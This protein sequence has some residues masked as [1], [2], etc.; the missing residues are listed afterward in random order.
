MDASPARGSR[1]SAS[2]SLEPACR[3]PAMKVSYLRVFAGGLLAI[4]LVLVL[5]F[6]QLP[7]SPAE[8][9]ARAGGDPGEAAG[10]RGVTVLLWYHP[11]GARRA[12]PDCAALYAI[13]GCIVTAN[14]SAYPRADAVLVPP[15]D[16][17]GNVSRLPQSAR[18]GA[19]K[20]IWMNFESPTHTK[21]LER[22]EGLFNMTMSYKLGSDIFVPYGYLERARAP[23]R[24]VPLPTKR[25]LVAWV[26]SNWNEAHA[27]VV[28]YWN[29]RRYVPIDVYGRA[30]AELVGDSVVRTV[31]AYKFYL[32]WEN[33]QHTD[34]ITEKL[35]H[36]ALQSSAVPV[37]LGPPRSNYE[38]FLPA[39]AFIHV[40]D[41][42]GPAQL[43]AYLRFL[44]RNPRS[45]LR[46]F[47]WKRRYTVHVASFWHEHYCAACAAVRASARHAKVVSDLALWFHA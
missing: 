40:D 25:R 28:F 15:R 31:S 26:V 21:H 16:I 44:A 14:R 41:F 13:P 8:P 24:R 6:R 37:V 5:C 29:L 30:G 20:W 10:A 46:Y 39:D 1:S 23:P 4:L 17:R 11:F 7:T 32:A 35:W 47:A 33:S 38:K 43:A 18:R 12:M 9:N 19:Q 22:L 36:N 42:S 2:R 45:Y 27:R 3:A 34:Y